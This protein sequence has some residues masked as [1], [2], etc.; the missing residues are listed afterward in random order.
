M[1]LAECCPHDT[2]TKVYAQIHIFD[3]H[4]TFVYSSALFANLLP[5]AR[6]R[7]W[8]G[9]SVCVCQVC[10][11]ACT[12]VRVSCTPPAFPVAFPKKNQHN[13]RND[14]TRT[15]TAFGCTTCRMNTTRCPPFIGNFVYIL[16]IIGKGGGKNFLSQPIFCWTSATVFTQKLNEKCK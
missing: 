13:A 5:W 8:K 1:F 15:H 16:S 6:A 7:P 3:T 12:F 11:C 9:E 10:N 2:R 14:L 4:N